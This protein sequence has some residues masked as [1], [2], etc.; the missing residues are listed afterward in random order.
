MSK[1]D[2]QGN[3]IGLVVF[4]LLT[5]VSG[6]FAY[7]YQSKATELEPKL[8]S[9]QRKEADLRAQIAKEEESYRA[10]KAKV[11]GSATNPGHQVVM[12]VIQEQLK[13]P[14]LSQERRDNMRSYSTLE[15][16]IVYLQ[17]ELEGADT[18]IGE[19]EAR[20]TELEKQMVDLNDQFKTD[21]T[22]ART[23][24]QEKY[25]A[26]LAKAEETLE[27]IATID[28]DIRDFNSRKAR[29]EAE[30]NKRVAEWE[31]KLEVLTARNDQLGDNLNTLAR[32]RADAAKLSFGEK[33][34]EIMSLND[35]G[36][37]AYI[38]LGSEDGLRSG[39][40][41]F[42]Y[43]R[44]HS[45]NYAET[46]KAKI[47]IT[48][49]IGPHSAMGTLDQNRRSD[50]VLAGDAIYEPSF[51]G[52]TETRVAYVGV[53]D[54]NGD[55]EPD[56][57]EFEQIVKDHNGQV[58]AKFDLKT[59]KINGRI[60]TRTDWLVI[61]DIPAPSKEEG[62]GP[63]AEQIKVL[64]DARDEFLKQARDAGVR[65][66]NARNFVIYLNSDGR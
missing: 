21:D 66:V 42:V 47:A 15:S 45:T 50:M 59:G 3:T 16:A 20:K 28:D 13:S 9:A 62:K 31:G 58:D 53:M 51:R 5:V 49:V 7:N 23:S 63:T 27:E 6:F 33:H 40:V 29:T 39:Q 24:Q 48:R 41:F 46:P 17:T 56:N 4:V 10:L 52:K 64:T 26:M 44:D 18:A 36:H 25:E 57:D 34:G 22:T 12:E 38:N 2:K 55:G 54:L 60:N 8:A 14:L 1:A 43:G 37:V 35:G 32:I 11:F 65:I 19:L 30:Y 61:G